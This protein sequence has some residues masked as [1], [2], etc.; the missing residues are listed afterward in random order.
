V[1]P[2]VTLLLT[3]AATVPSAR[4]GSARVSTDLPSDLQSETVIQVRRIGGPSPVLTVDAATVDWDVWAGESAPDAGD[5]EDIAEAT[6]QDVRVWFLSELVGRTVSTAHGAAVFA[7][8]REL[9][10]PGRRPTADPDLRRVGGTVQVTTH[11]H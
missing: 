1:Y 9:S 11:S 4:F 2:P 10:G 5:A 7:R 6:A 8:V 3:T